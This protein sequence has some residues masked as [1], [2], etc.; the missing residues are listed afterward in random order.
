[1]NRTSLAKCL[2]RSLAAAI[3]AGFATSAL[4]QTT[5]VKFAA[6]GDYGDGPG[7]AAVAQL[8]NS[9]GADFIVTVGDNCYDSVPIATQVGNLYG[10]WV[11]GARFWPSLGNHD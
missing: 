11:T 4:G 5:S 7:S 1:M 9:R 6:F 3:F 8:V 10:N 2:A